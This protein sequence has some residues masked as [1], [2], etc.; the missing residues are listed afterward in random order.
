MRGKS[1]AKMPLLLY[2]EEVD[3]ALI[4]SNEF[5]RRGDAADKIEVTN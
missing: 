2:V 4:Q 5:R 1:G 3:R